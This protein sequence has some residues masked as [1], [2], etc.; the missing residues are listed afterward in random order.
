MDRMRRKEMVLDKI[1]RRAVLFLTAAGC[2]FLAGI[3]QVQAEELPTGLKQAEFYD[4][5]EMDGQELPEIFD[6]EKS[7][8]KR[9]SSVYNNAWDSYSTNYYYNMLSDSQKSLWDALD[10]MCLSY[11]TGSADV[12]Y[13]QN[14]YLSSRVMYTG[15]SKLQAQNVA[16][17]FKYSNPQYY[18]V[19][20]SVY[21]LSNATMGYLALGIYSD[22]ASGSARAAATEQ[23]KSVIDDWMAQIQAQPTDLLKEKKAH[24][25]ICEKV[26]YDNAYGSAFENKYNQVAYSVFCTDTTVCAG[27]SQAMLLLL[28]GAGIDC[29]AV[30]SEKHEWN[31][32]RLDGCWYYVD[33]TWDDNIADDSGLTAAYTYFNRSKEKFLSDNSYNVEYHTAES[34]LDGYLPQLKY[35]SGATVTEIGTIFTPSA[36]LE[37]PVISQNGSYVTITAPSGGTVYYTIDGTMPSPASTKSSRYD[38]AFSVS[39]PVVV[40]AMEVA[41]GYYDSSSSSVTVIPNGTV[42]FSANGGYIGSKSILSVSRNVLLG[43]QVGTLPS[44]KRRNYVFLGWYTAAGGGNKVSAAMT[45]SQDQTLY[46]HWAKVHPKKATITSVKNSGSKK[47]AVK[48]RKM[49]N[50]SGY[51]I[52]YALNRS[53]KSAK[54]KTVS[55]NTVT[56]NKL[57]K[58]KT[59][60][61]QVRMFQK[62]SG[63]GKKSYGSWSNIKS[64]KI[65][66]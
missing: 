64:V 10:T 37:A 2:L 55:S 22:F 63:S 31:I 4:M 30:T 40:T 19:D 58:G 34:Y 15:M 36:T 43:A 38:K 7:S 16:L 39:Q 23:M 47:M 32:V 44:A 56:I 35:D 9:G 49:S 51:Q 6:S 14:G 21:T 53:M 66:K 12:S 52:R 13:S 17:M 65:K 45:V 42:T 60:Y 1:K 25:L 46:A 26:T 59:Y 54:K 33:C 20:T 24:D 27:Y 48:I 18:F 28:N 50:A 8:Q 3:V 61:V 62:D 57:K 29:A 41:E 11:L 5:G